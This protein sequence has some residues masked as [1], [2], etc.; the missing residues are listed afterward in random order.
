MLE[1]ADGAFLG[2]AFFDF[3]VEVGAGVGV[4]AEPAEHDAVEGG[5]GGSV[6]A[7]VEPV[8]G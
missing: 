4:P 7:A 6:P 8:G 5:V 3:A 2:F 1:A